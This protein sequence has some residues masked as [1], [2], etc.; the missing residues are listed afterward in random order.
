[1]LVSSSSSPSRVPVPREKVRCGCRERKLPVMQV[2]TIQTDHFRGDL[3]ISKYPHQRTGPTRPGL[4]QG[5]SECLLRFEKPPLLLHVSILALVIFRLLHSVEALSGRLRFPLMYIR[6]SIDLHRASAVEPLSKREP[7][8]WFRV[9]LRRSAS[10]C[11][12]S[13]AIS[14][15]SGSTASS[16]SSSVDENGGGAVGA[17]LSPAAAIKIPASHSAHA[18]PTPSMQSNLMPRSPSL[19]RAACFPSAAA[20]SPLNPG[21]EPSIPAHTEVADASWR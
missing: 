3:Y 2:N 7:A 20:A 14:P 15:G 1:M 9:Q 8:N 21:K 4:R 5:V 11:L 6:R 13:A 10:A 16:A 19:P 12:P 17:G 18:L